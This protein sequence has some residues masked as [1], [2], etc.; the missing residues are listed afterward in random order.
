[1]NLHDFFSINETK[2]IKKANNLFKQHVLMH[3]DV[4]LYKIS[5]VE[6]SFEKFNGTN[7]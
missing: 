4:V 5:V 1:M 7:L 6:Y 2:I 3:P